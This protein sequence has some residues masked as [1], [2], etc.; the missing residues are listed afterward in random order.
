MTSSSKV[1]AIQFFNRTR[2][3]LRSST[4]RCKNS[5]RGANESRR[6][7]RYLPVL[8]TTTLF[9]CASVV[10]IKSHRDAWMTASHFLFGKDTSFET[11]SFFW[12]TFYSRG[13]LFK[14]LFLVEI[15]CRVSLTWCEVFAF[16]ARS[17]CCSLL[18][19]F[20][21]LCYISKY[22]RCSN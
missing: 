14:V 1:T 2:F 21:K 20:R 16:R 12:S 6:V 5:I 19:E 11:L 3:S 8:P 15:I 7:V 4:Y 18:G 13:I 9:C 17:V 10:G 22:L